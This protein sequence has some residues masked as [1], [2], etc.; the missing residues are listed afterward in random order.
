MTTASPKPNRSPQPSS[1]GTQSTSTTASAPPQPFCHTFDLTKRLFPLPPSFSSA[2]AALPID[3][4][5]LPVPPLFSPSSVHP[6]PFTSLLQSLS[7]SLTTSSP[8]TQHRVIIP[9]LLSPALYAP[10]S[11]LPT[12]LLPFLHSLRALLRTHPTRL[13]AMLSLPLSLHPRS[14]GLTR[15]IEHLVDGVLELAPFAH[16]IELPD[17]RAGAGSASGQGATAK[18]GAEEKA[19]GMLKVHK[20]PVVSERGGG[21]VGTQGEDMVFLVGRKRIQIRPFYLPPVEALGGEGGEGGQGAEEKTKKAE[22]E[23]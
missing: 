8:T 13:T 11:S 16:T 7:T 9:L 20:L 10:S 12:T 14:S 1:S 19:Q 18:T 3:Y 23:F 17:G 15:W 4:I 2:P 21:G 22:M 5:H 6:S